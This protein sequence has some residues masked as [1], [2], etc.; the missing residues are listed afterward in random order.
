[1]A[2]TVHADTETPEIVLTP[3][4]PEPADVVPEPAKTEFSSTEPEPVTISVEE[5]TRQ[6]T[7]E[8]P[9]ADVHIKTTKTKISY[10]TTNGHGED[11][12]LGY[13]TRLFKK[14]ALIS[15]GTSTYYTG[16][17]LNHP[18]VLRNRPEPLKNKHISA[19]SRSVMREGY[20]L[21]FT[22]PVLRHNYDVHIL[23]KPYSSPN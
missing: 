9:E 5:T 18:T 3:V 22:M 8:A 11:V 21:G 6:S 4:Q 16:H 17:L 7:K 20:E 19:R 1:M 13:K 2:D 14:A 23:F 15:D 10:K 12:D